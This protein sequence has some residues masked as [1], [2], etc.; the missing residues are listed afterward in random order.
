MG[1]ASLISTA[2]SALSAIASALA[3]SSAEQMRRRASRKRGG[4]RFASSRAGASR[5]S[6]ASR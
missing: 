6:S 4:N 5:M 1:T 2:A 3:W